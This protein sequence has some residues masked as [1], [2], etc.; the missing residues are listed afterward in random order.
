MTA[1]QPRHKAVPFRGLTSA[2]VEASRN[3]HGANVLTPPQ[4]DPWW[5]LFLEKFD[6]PV[7][8]ILIIAAVV[9]VLTG[10]VDGKYVEGVGIIVAILLATTLAFLNEY[11]AAKEFDILNEVNNEVPVKVIRDGDYKTVPKK[12]LVVGDIVLIELGEEVP[13]DGRLLEAVSL[14]V[15]EACL[16]GE[17]VPVEKTTVDRADGDGGEA[18]YPANRVFRGTFVSDGHGT[19]EVAA[20]GDFTE[21]GHIAKPASEETGGQTPLN[22]QLERLSKLIGVL[23]FLVAGLIYAAL[24]ARGVVSGELNSHR[25]AMVLLRYLGG[26]RHHRS[27]AGM[28]AYRL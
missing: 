27:C 12:D 6:D 15:D 24:V 7:I 3:E 2:E 9:A 5:H 18:V 28:G 16:T 25:S 4:R 22:L 26:G 11:R 8:R 10:I 14:Q 21:I 13:C 1:M 23:G 20:V 17:S 19:I